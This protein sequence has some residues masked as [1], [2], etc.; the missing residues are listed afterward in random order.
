MDRYLLAWA[1][2]SPEV[3]QTE[4]LVLGSGI[5][6]LYTAIKASD[7]FRVTVVT[8]K[9][10][11]DSNTE[12]AQGGIAAAMD[13]EDSPAFHYEDTLSAGAGLCDPETVKI[14][15]EEGPLRVEELIAMGAQFDYEGASLA[16][17]REGAHS[18]RRVLHAK[19]DATGGEIERTLVQAAR[20]CPRIQVRENRFVVDLLQNREGAVLGALV[21]NTEK[22]RPEAYLAKVVVLATGGVGQVF[23][24]TTNPEVATAD[25]MA[26]AWRAGAALMDMEFLQFHPTAI[27]LAGAPRFLISEAVRGEGGQLIN[28]DGKRFM[29]GIPGRELA[30][31]DVVTRAIWK[32][33]SQGEVYLDFRPIG[34]DKILR[35]FPSIRETC[36]NYGLD[37]LEAPIPV[38]PAAHY[39]MGGVRADKYGRTTLANLYASGECAC[40]GVHGATRLASNSLLDGL[41]FGARIVERIKAEALQPLPRWSEV[42]RTGARG[43]AAAGEAG[44]GRTPARRDD[45]PHGRA[46]EESMRSALQRLMWDKVGIQRRGGDLADAVATL[47]AWA[48]GFSPSAEEKDL[49]LVNMLTVGWLM[50]K[51]ALARRESRGAHYRADYPQRSDPEWGKHS[52]VSRRDEGV[53]YVPTGGDC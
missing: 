16:F 26:A 49:E 27:H 47:E 37:V 21:F 51:S 45:L 6:G 11:E 18:R 13:D 5:A 12:H 34:R 20:L 30:P 52:L 25:G 3:F 31:R 36:R 53:R 44:F 32:E 38:A 39:M 46:E 1:A 42:E 17:T 22:R 10:I 40:N 41:V 4:V 7:S 8:K 9:K 19:G 35:R 43:E 50:A 14:L 15:V 2:E 48:G 33:M 28:R 24:H 29:D 23:G